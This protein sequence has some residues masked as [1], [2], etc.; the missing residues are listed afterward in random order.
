MA[1]SE[2]IFK[3]NHKQATD[4]ISFDKWLGTSKLFPKTNYHIL[5]NFID[6]SIFQVDK[7]ANFIQ[8]KR[9]VTVFQEEEDSNDHQRL[10]RVLH[11]NS[12]FKLEGV[13]LLYEKMSQTFNETKIGY[14]LKL[15]GN[16]LMSLA[17]CGKQR[18]HSDNPYDDEN[19]QATNDSF[20][21]ILAIQDNTKL[22]FLNKHHVRENIE[23]NAGQLLVARGSFIH[24]GSD[25]MQENI[26]FHFYV[27]APKNGR[28]KDTTY[29]LDDKFEI[30][31]HRYERLYTVRSNLAMQSF[32]KYRLKQEKKKEFF[33]N[34]TNHKLAKKRTL[35]TKAVD[36]EVAY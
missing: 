35:H 28:S 36:N 20:I 19:I 12:A 1:I 5:E 9:G 34:I 23:L 29:F 24:G 3:C 17:G 13:P 8:Q 15:Q 6:P 18:L 32:S 25:Y 22:H 2:G 11:E 33:L 26:R 14:K 21:C 31:N 4:Y 27:D 10:Q 30:L 16:L 7:L